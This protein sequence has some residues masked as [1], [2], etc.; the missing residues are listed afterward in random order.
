MHGLPSPPPILFLYHDIKRVIVSCWLKNDGIRENA[1]D[2][3]GVL[4]QPKD[5]FYY[6]FDLLTDKMFIRIHAEYTACML[7]APRGLYDPS[8]KGLLYLGL[9]V[10]GES[11]HVI[12]VLDGGV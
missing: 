1:A 12:P 2:Q 8:L 9:L 10:V 11:G 7:F 3:R 5:P 6:C 4:M